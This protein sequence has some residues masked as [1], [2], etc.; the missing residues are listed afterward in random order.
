VVIRA[1]LICVLVLS[2]VVLSGC[3]SKPTHESVMKDMVG[4][5]KELV[6]VLEGV[7]DEAS[8]ESAKPK[9]QALSKE[10]KELEVTASKLPKASDEEEKRLRE[11]Y[12]PELEAIQ[13]KLGA[14]MI[15][16]ATDPKLGSVL[17]DAMG[18]GS[19]ADAM[20]GL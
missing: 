3:D 14:Q 4:K 5:M 7:K 17:K 11:K 9:L 10:M 13:P 6:A 8:A 20:P 2:A 18:D 19:A 12:Q 15:R 16:I 1:R